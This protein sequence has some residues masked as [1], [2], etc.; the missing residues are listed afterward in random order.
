VGK[1]SLLGT[2]EDCV[3]RETASSIL[4]GTFG[5][6]MTSP[7]VKALLAVT[8]LPS[9]EGSDFL[10]KYLR[11]G[12]DGLLLLSR[13]CVSSGILSAETFVTLVICGRRNWNDDLRLREAI[14]RFWSFPMLSSFAC[15]AAE[16]SSSLSNGISP[17]R[18]S[19]LR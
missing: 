7:D 5:M 19:R 2:A 1:G 10:R 13:L 16:L 18:E 8:E 3:T 9:F 17:D 12:D 6:G 15:D 4:G 11:L 14:R